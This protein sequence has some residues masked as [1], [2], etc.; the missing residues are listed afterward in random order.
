MLLGEE[1][2]GERRVASSNLI[3]VI[4]KSITPS[5]AFFLIVLRA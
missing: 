5:P 4:K 2:A 3:P 1:R